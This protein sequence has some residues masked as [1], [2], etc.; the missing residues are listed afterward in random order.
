MTR[1]EPTAEVTAL[2]TIEKPKRVRK[3][4]PKTDSEGRPCL[5]R[6]GHVARCRFVDTPPA[7]VRTA[8]KA[9]LPKATPATTK[10]LTVIL[11]GGDPE[12]REAAA[13][14]V[15]WA[16]E[17]MS[18]H[19]DTTFIGHPQGPAAGAIALQGYRISIR[20]GGG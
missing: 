9:T 4:C 1:D 15:R 14:F 7:R 10:R 11:L 8:R 17:A 2:A 19:V 6:P 5:K 13:E 18:P 12:A 16:M 3:P 20:D